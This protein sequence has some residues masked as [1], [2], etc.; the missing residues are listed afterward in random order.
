[1]GAISP[2]LYTGEFASEPDNDYH[3]V[4]ANLTRKI[5]WNGELSLTASRGQMRQNEPL[6]APMNCQ[7]QFGIDL[8]PTGA[9]T[10]PYLFDCADWNAPAALSRTRAD[11][12]IETSMLAGR[13]VLQPTRRITWRGDLRYDKQDYDG[14]YQAFNPL[15][16]QY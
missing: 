13:V 7:G 11:L 14:D 5:P 8:S 2:A 4:R 12:T 15:T 3:N 9:P 6:L 10:N 16:G 1:P